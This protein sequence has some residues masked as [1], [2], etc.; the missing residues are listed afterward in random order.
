MVLNAGLLAVST[1]REWISLC[2]MNA[3]Q[4]VVDHAATP[5]IAGSYFDTFIA[6]KFA[7]DEHFRSKLLELAKASTGIDDRKSWLNNVK[8][9][10]GILPI[11]LNADDSSVLDMFLNG[12]ADRV[13]MPSVFAGPDIMM[14]VF[15]VG[16]KFSSL[17]ENVS[18]SESEKNGETTDP[19]LLYAFRGRKKLNGMD[20][21]EEEK[22]MPVKRQKLREQAKE[23]LLFISNEKRGHVILR[24]EFPESRFVP[25]LPQVR[26]RFNTLYDVELFIDMDNASQLFESVEVDTIAK[27]LSS[28]KSI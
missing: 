10:L 11:H 28:R 18:K 24:F 27:F 20:E 13:L 15:V 7:W 12:N 23:R 5:Q 26:T 3:L 19:R 9:P 16:N 14:G 1:R 8:V 2:I 22:T 25:S 6:M 4:R 17:Q 21:L